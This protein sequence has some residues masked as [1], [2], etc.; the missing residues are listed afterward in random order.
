[1]SSKQKKEHTMQTYNTAKLAKMTD[2][3]LRTLINDL[4]ATNDGD[5]MLLSNRIADY[6]DRRIARNSKKAAAEGRRISNP[7]GRMF[8]NGLTLN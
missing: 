4:W 5:Q 3:E 8:G 1:M 6:L 7:I 2:S